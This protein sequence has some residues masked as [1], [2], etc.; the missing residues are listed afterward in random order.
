[1]SNLFPDEEARSAYEIDYESLYGQGY[2]GII[3]DIDNTLVYPDAPADDAS[4]SFIQKLKEMGFKVT[5][6]S[7]NGKSRVKTFAD[8]IGAQY[9]CKALKPRA[10]GYR[11]AM[12][13]M[14]TDPGTTVCIGDQLF[15]DIWGA[16]RLGIHA[17]LTQPFTLKEEIQIRCKRLLEKPVLAR[18][19]RLQSEKERS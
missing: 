4:V 10:M 8:A 19:R 15:T 18:Y 9:V 1:M 11:K 6:V 14:G 13:I 3:Y 12:E 5:V 16:R 17:V 2:R 7:N